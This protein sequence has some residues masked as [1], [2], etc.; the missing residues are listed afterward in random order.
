MNWGPFPC[1]D[2][3]KNLRA[4]ACLD[5]DSLRGQVK[6][7]KQTPLDIKEGRGQIILV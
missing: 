1:T 4:L 3:A 2:A 6:L 5:R 7:T